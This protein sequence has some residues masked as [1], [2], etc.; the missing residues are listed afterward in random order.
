[1]NYRIVLNQLG[2]LFVV[3]SVCMVGCDAAAWLM[4]IFEPGPAH[5]DE[6]TAR[7]SLLSIAGLSAALGSLTWRLTR[8]APIDLG[9]REALLLTTATWLLG[10][11]LAGLPFFIWAHLS[12]HASDD[13]P[14]GSLADCYFEAM[15]GLTTTGASVLGSAP[16]DIE[17]LP[18]SLLLWRSATHWLG[19]LG[20]VVLFVAV[21]PGLGVGGKKLYR[22]ESSGLDLEGVRPQI[23][24]TARLLWI[25]YLVLT[26]AQVVAL[27]I[28]GMTLFDSVCVSFGTLATGGFAITNASIGQYDS[29]AIEAVTITFMALG[30]VNFGL[31][32]LLLRRKYRSVF[33]DVELRVY[34]L[35]M[36]CGIAIAAIALF[37]RGTPIVRT[38]GGEVEATFF[39]SLRIATFDT[40]SIQTTTGF[41]ISD[42]NQWPFIAKMAL[43]TLMFAGGCAGSTAGGFK[44]IRLWIALKV[45]AVEFERVFRPNVIRPL[46]VGRT[47]LDEQMK[48]ANI[49]FVF[50]YVF[51]FA[52]GGVLIMLLEQALNPQGGCDYATASSATI[53]SLSNVG[54]GMGK[55]GAVGS[56]GW[57]SEPSKV[58]LALLMAVGRL[59]I[60]GILV[61]FMP[62]F[63]KRD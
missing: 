43:F 23:R 50:T 59:E 4:L 20:I 17:S 40:V 7:W 8:G 14:F 51:I 48:L 26:G 61:L 24:D 13:H 35:L 42:T 45:L 2:L 11:V 25:M 36:F 41:N 60:F 22:A 29:I 16:N 18:G 49:C 21:L 34:L 37:S 53:A 56:Y 47:V 30:G 31:Y 52:I 46:R 27:C 6:W 58:V 44:I 57:L 1:V 38:T 32:Y 9:R 12:T 33:S 54:P 28:A 19:G 10:A 55:V 3:L 15:S 39:Q 5:A 63:W 62:K